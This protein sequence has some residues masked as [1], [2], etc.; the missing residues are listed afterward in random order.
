MFA[1]SLRSFT[2]T[3]P[4][5]HLSSACNLPDRFDLFTTNAVDFVVHVYRRANVVGDN[6]ESLADGVSAI[7]FGHVEMTVFF[8]EA[9][10]LGCGI[11]FDKS[12]AAAV[13]CVVGI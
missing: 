4:S 6:H 7:G 10:Y 3:T 8:R 1:C 9:F 11:F 2:I 13:F 12:E 5:T